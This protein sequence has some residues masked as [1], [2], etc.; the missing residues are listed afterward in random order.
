MLDLG[1]THVR[2]V[3]FIWAAAAISPCALT[4]CI[5]E[6]KIARDPDDLV[7]GAMLPFAGEQAATGPNLEYTLLLLEE[8]VNRAGG[9]DGR[10]LRFVVRDGH[11]DD[12]RAA[13]TARELVREGAVAVIGPVNARTAKVVTPLFAEA[14]VLTV[15]GAWAVDSLDASERLIRTAPSSLALASVLSDRAKDDGVER[16]AVVYV[17]D[18]Y[19]TPFAE[20]LADQFQKVGGKNAQTLT[21]AIKDSQ[22]SFEYVAQEVSRFEADAV[23]L[24]TYLRQAAEVALALPP[25]RLYLTSSLKNKLLLRNVPDKVFEGA[26]GVSPAVPKAEFEVFSNAFE[27][28][29]GESPLAEAAFFYD[30]TALVALSLQRALTDG[31][32]LKAD[33]LRPLLIDI[34]RSSLG[35]SASWLRLDEA[36]ERV[37]DGDRV[38][39]QG[40]SGLVNL[41]DNGQVGRGLAELWEVKDGDISTIELRAATPK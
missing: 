28:R 40:V 22:T 35:S 31:A 4:G 30:A 38:N 18:G 33:A 29:W 25:T 9:I 17:A 16:L 6:S 12:G 39:Y 41:D 10:K 20:G 36:L 32:E 7:I 2:I 21:L 1:G 3:R 8:T 27:S 19:G 37:A 5:E 14:G 26:I 34:S 11:T 15:T 24:V 13:Q 23:V